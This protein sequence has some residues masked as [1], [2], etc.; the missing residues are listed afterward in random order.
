MPDLRIY[1]S[2]GGRKSHGVESDKKRYS[3]LISEMRKEFDEYGLVLT[4]A[5]SAGKQFI[6]RGYDV[7]VLAEKLH[8]I[9]L[10]SYDYH[11][12]FESEHKSVLKSP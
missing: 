8:L 7:P 6:D 10:M 2:S 11:G 12:W 4:A 1:F 5:V 3:L 9:A